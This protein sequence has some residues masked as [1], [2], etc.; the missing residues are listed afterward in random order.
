MAVTGGDQRASWAGLLAW[1]LDWCSENDVRLLGDSALERLAADIGAGDLLSAADKVH[2]A[3]TASGEPVFRRWLK[4]AFGDLEVVDDSLPEALR[5]VGLPILTTN[6]DGL[7][8][9]ALGLQSTTWLNPA[10]FQRLL[11]DPVPAMVAHLHGHWLEPESIVLGMISYGR[12]VQAA[13]IQEM[14]KAVLNLRSIVFVGYG[15]GFDDPNFDGLLSYLRSEVVPGDYEHF[16][17]VREAEYEVVRDFHSSEPNLTVL[18]YGSEYSLLPDAIRG[19]LDESQ[20]VSR[21]PE[22]QI[23][24]SDVLSLPL[25]GTGYALGPTFD[26]IWPDLVI[27]PPVKRWHHYP[28]IVSLSE[29]NERSSGAMT[30]VIGGAGSGKS[31]ALRM[32]YMEL[33]NGGDQLGAVHYLSA[34]EFVAL[35]FP[36]GGRGH[37]EVV[38]VDGLDELGDS[39]LAKALQNLD[40][41]NG[42]AWVSART[43]LVTSS[44]LFNQFVEDEASEVVEMLPWR[45]GEVRLYVERFAQRQDSPDARARIE[46]LVGTLAHNELLSSPLLLFLS[47]YLVSGDTKGRTV[48][49]NK[50][51][52]YHEFYRAWLEREVR[53]GTSNQR[54]VPSVVAGHAFLGRQIYRRRLA[55][56]RSAALLSDLLLGS[57]LDTEELLTQS[58]FTQLLGLQDGPTGVECS[59]FRH[60]TFGEFLVAQRTIDS[61]TAGP[62]ALRDW[63]D[64]AFNDDINSFVR[65]GFA[66]IDVD[67][68]LRMSDSLADAYGSLLLSDESNASEKREILLYYAGRLELPECP[69]ILVEGYFGETAFVLRR[70]AALGSILHGRD[71]INL[72]F[73]SQL[74]EDEQDSAKNRA[75]QLVYFGDQGG[76][77]FDSEDT[78]GS[79]DR[80]RT[81]IFDR[82]KEQSTRAR[83]LRDWDLATLVSLAGSRPDTEFSEAETELLAGLAIDQ[84]GRIPSLDAALADMLG[85]QASS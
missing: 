71:D 66:L 41:W 10:G 40:R 68:R 5:E 7:L 79:W 76:D 17:L 82:L 18:S 53:R 30:L 85:R 27:D 21:N 6:Y 69:E 59:G 16:R 3:L 28:E 60:E 42:G 2:R 55:G 4:D 48:P 65:S 20:Y 70:A 1:T 74:V 14:L 44:T 11:R 73:V 33:V 67:E 77:I 13:H 58:S 31:T 57:G 51:E 46:R 52:L 25:L 62:D 22:P 9:R 72:D 8:E 45:D 50:Y 32:R 19:L 29:F 81:A 24:T 78:L 39:G 12:V 80:T 49:S 75:I 23:P 56:M 36:V 38:L 54:L 61:L 63:L 15:G 47:I 43:H 84:A 35:D 83:R 34:D 64:V 37:G 26:L